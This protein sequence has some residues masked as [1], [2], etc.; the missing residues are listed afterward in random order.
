MFGTKGWNSLVW[1]ALVT[2][3]ISSAIVGLCFANEFQK[4]LKSHNKPVL[5]WKSCGEANNHTLQCSRLEVPVN[6][7]N[8]S[9]DKT[10][11]LP[12]IRMLAK[13]ASATGDRHIFLNPGG[14][15]ASGMGLLRGSA[16]DLNK[17]VGEGFHLLSFDPR[18]VSGSIP[19]AVCYQNTGE[20]ATAFASN[21]W[22]LEYQAG[23]MYTRAEN[24]AKACRDM[25]GEHGEYINTPQTAYDMNLILDAIG[26][27]NMY[28]W[29]LS[30]GTTLGQTYA[31]MFP[32]QISRMVLDG[33]SNL[34]QW[35]N[36]FFLEESLTDTDKIYT[37][38]LKECFEAKE[39]CPLQSIKG[40]HFKSAGQLQSYF[41]GFLR[42]LEDEPIPVYLNSTDYGAITRRTIVSNGILM[43]LYKPKSWPL[44]AKNLAE[45]LNGNN[46]PAYN[47]YSESWLLK[48]LVDDSTI[49]IGLNDNRKT[50]QDA[51]VHGVKPVYNHTISRPELSFLVSRYQASDIYDR[52]SWSI[53]TTHNFRPQY[54]P[55]Y[56]RIRTAEPILIL[57][58]TWD[59]ACPLVS[60]KKAHNSFEGARLVEQLSYGH[61]SLSMPSLCTVSY[62]RHYFNEGI[63]PEPSNR[64]GI[65][66][67]YFP[68][69]WGSAVSTLSV[70][71]EDLLRSLHA[72]AANDIF[73]V[74]YQI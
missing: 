56:P 1:C 57:S 52:A 7:L 48:Y 45:L 2:T 43:A 64:C 58:T 40:E 38:F 62:L 46:T 8:Q 26:Q 27:K 41:D 3:Y 67:E 32:E 25:M 15:G 6:H 29:G 16:S 9:S 22:N 66:T 23:E 33:V 13:N 50:G 5:Q 18:G 53:P 37:G 21:P 14:P 24:K 31:Q 65:D 60:A 55:E 30:Y 70:K 4:P 59:P 42:E 47:A 39:D 28:Y 72:L 69:A 49:F 17:L 61:C 10:F 44:L 71:D 73:S 19:K 34:D 20:R 74:R 68:S 36:S 63:L 11:S 35:Y 12:I 54:Y 51:P